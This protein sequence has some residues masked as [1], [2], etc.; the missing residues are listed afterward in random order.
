MYSV[1]MQ[2]VYSSRTSFYAQD[3]ENTLKDDT[4]SCRN[5]SKL[6]ASEIIVCNS[7]YINITLKRKLYWASQAYAQ[8]TYL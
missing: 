8:A 3:F 1:I 7:S 5:S 4:Q 6:N 2:M